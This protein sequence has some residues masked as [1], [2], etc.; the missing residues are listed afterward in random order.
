[1][2][3]PPKDPT[4]GPPVIDAEAA[5]PIALAH[6]PALI[7][8]LKGP[9]HVFEYFNDRYRLLVGDRAVN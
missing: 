2:Y 8:I 3:T 7:C 4:T 5:Y 6:A 9:E 1:M